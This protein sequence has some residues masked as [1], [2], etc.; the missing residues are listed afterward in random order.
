MDPGK[1]TVKTM[2]E[3]QADIL[4]VYVGVGMFTPEE[5]AGRP[6]EIRI[7]RLSLFTGH[8]ELASVAPG[9]FNPSYLVIDRSRR[10]LYA[11]DEVNEFQGQGG[12]GASAFAIDQDS[13]GLTLLNHQPVYGAGPCHLSID[14]TG[15]WLLAANYAGGSVSVL[16]IEENGRLGT[17]T[18]VVQHRAVSTGPASQPIPHAH[19]TLQDPA[20]RYILAADLGLDRIMIY[21][22]DTTR[23][24]VTPHDVPSV[25]VRLGAGPRHLAFHPNGQHLYCVN[26]LDSTISVFAYDAARGLPI[27]RQTLSTLPD[28]FSGTSYGAHL[29]FAPSGRFLYVSNRG[30]DSLAVFAVDGE[31]GL[32]TP[33]SHVSTQ[34]QFPRHFAIDPTGSYLLVANQRSDTLVTFRVDGEHGDLT[35]I[36]VTST[37]TPMCVQFVRLNA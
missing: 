1:D 18:E 21:R 19:S 7:Y 27:E 17:A 6:E 16:P 30:H 29:Q 3:A 36:Q 23:G 15:K 11:V 5:P 34:G 37:E 28:G 25:S 35:P 2:M 26:E 10:Y 12:G 8:M 9:A 33:Q 22:L 20:G 4:Y 13:G 14:Q 32:L 24:A 31:T